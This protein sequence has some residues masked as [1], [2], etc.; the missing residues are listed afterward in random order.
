MDDAFTKVSIITYDRFVFWSSKQQKSESV[1]S[2][3]GRLIEQVENYSLGDEE[4]TLIKDTFILNMMDHDT[5]KQ[6]LKEIFLPTK[7][8][9][10]AIQLEMGAQNQ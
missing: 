10:V 9:E 6:L 5:Q 4:T 1:D 2:F 3:Y 7:A 8:I